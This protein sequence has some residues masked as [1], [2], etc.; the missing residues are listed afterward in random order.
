[1]NLA[2]RDKV[3]FVTLLDWFLY[4]DVQQ[5]QVLNDTKLSCLCTLFLRRWWWRVPDAGDTRV[6]ADWGEDGLRLADWGEDRLSVGDRGEDWLRGGGC[7]P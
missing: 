6:A 7:L 3:R 5:V 1:M 4:F 2:E